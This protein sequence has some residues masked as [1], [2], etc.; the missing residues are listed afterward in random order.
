MSVTRNAETQHRT[1][2]GPARPATFSTRERW[3]LV[4]ASLWLV[5]GLQLD[6]FAHST[7]PDLETFWT[8]WH[9]VM[10]SGIAACGLTLLWLLR[11]RLPEAVTYR[12]LLADTPRALR[13]PVVG[14]ALLLVGGA[15]DTLW[16][17]LFGI[18]K[19]LEIFVSPSHYFI[20]IGMV[21][22]ASGPALMVAASA[23]TRRLRGG[24]AVMV[25]V[26]AVLAL[27]P[28]I[29]YTEHA[30]A[31]ED[32]LLGTVVQQEWETFSADAQM[33]HAYVGSTVVLLT[34]LLI[35]GRRWHLPLG[36]PTAVVA[37]PT[38]TIGL[39]MGEIA[40]L[41]LPVT[42]AVATVA[43]EVAA[44]A[45]APRFAG[46]SADVR[47]V[48]LGF[49]APVV[50]WGAVLAAGATAGGG[51]AWNLHMVSG[52]LTLL[53]LTGAATAYVVRRIQPAPA[54]PALAAAA[55]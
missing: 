33:V 41:W 26:S 7:I 44:R 15:I 11:S 2:P 42:L 37:V 20:I 53:G 5:F 46:L 9:A 47:W 49:A 24:D 43:V 22:V 51:L 12:S 52:L 19:G 27:L 34:A 16:H 35:L 10:Y 25:V 13:L 18:E 21:L 30:S 45:L 29:I 48:V 39:A 1:E 6:A 4:G 14:M 31:L 50:V 3:V 32:P 28:V 38:F 8:P 54:V 55:R 40:N 17:N 23:A 36:A